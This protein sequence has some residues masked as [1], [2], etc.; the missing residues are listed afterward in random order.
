MKTSIENLLYLSDTSKRL[1]CMPYSK[2][3][4]DKMANDLGLKSD[5]LK[6]DHYVVPED[7]Y[8]DIDSSVSKVSTT[9]LFRS[10]Y[11]VM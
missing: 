7:V 8:N 6:N 9:T 11:N 2:E 10:L 3:N 5:W 1:I 4:M